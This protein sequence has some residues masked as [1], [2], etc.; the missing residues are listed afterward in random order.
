MV[1]NFYSAIDVKLVNALH[2]LEQPL[3]DTLPWRGGLASHRGFK[4]AYGGTPL[5]IYGIRLII[6]VYNQEAEAQTTVLLMLPY[7]LYTCGRDM[8]LKLGSTGN[9]LTPTVRRMKS[10]N[11]Q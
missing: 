5:Y 8:D 6:T 9:R 4:A 1:F 2:R 3:G 10:I 11:H 7:L